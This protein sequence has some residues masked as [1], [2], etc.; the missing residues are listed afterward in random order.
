MSCTT[1]TINVT[2]AY[3]GMYPGGC[4][5]KCPCDEMAA[6][7]GQ[8][9]DIL[10][11]AIKDKCDGTVRC[12]KENDTRVPN[13]GTCDLPGTW[14]RRFIHARYNCWEGTK[15]KRAVQAFFVAYA[16]YL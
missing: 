9:D 5:P 13:S 14:Q 15:G 7:E 8:T 4:D 2:E 12:D 6:C 11:Q 16:T 3:W 1:G 10:T